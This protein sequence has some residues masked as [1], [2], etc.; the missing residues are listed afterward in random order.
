MVWNLF[1]VLAVLLLKELRLF[2]RGG[3]VGNMNAS[4]DSPGLHIDP[5]ARSSSAVHSVILTLL[6]KGGPF[7]SSMILIAQIR[8]LASHV[9]T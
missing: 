8:V 7:K 2:Q 6:P 5:E 3:Y 9:V 4:N 1:S